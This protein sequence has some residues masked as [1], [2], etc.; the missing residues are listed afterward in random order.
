MTVETFSQP[1]THASGGMHYSPPVDGENASFQILSDELAENSS[2]EGLLTKVLSVRKLKY[3]KGD[4]KLM[5]SDLKDVTEIATKIV[6]QLLGLNHLQ[7]DQ[8]KDIQDVDQMT[9][10]IKARVYKLKDAIKNKKFR[11]HPQLLELTFLTAE[12]FECLEH[13]FNLNQGIGSHSDSSVHSDP[14]ATCTP[15]LVFA[16]SPHPAPSLS[17]EPNPHL[18]TSPHL[19][20]RKQKP[21]NEIKDRKYQRERSEGDFL[22]F[23]EMALNQNIEVGQLAGY[24]LQRQYYHINR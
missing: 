11:K 23:K 4:V 17:P 13:S 1:S 9:K 14:V 8:P 12:E 16:P 24:F 22:S 20:P 7:L 21:L 3:S 10:I 15:A 19:N 18:A 5:L 2:L 6:D